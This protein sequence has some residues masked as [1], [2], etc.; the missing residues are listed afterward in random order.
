MS[1]NVLALLPEYILTITG[2]VI[3]LA[4]PIF[5]AANAR[6]PLGWLAILG[7]LGAGLARACPAGSPMN[8]EDIRSRGVLVGFFVRQA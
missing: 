7:T 5:P 6:K 4:D 1:P 2:V 3:M 8:G